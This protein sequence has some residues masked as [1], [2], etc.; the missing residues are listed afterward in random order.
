MNSTTNRPS[1]HKNPSNLHP[2]SKSNIG[3]A[4]S[5]SKLSLKKNPSIGKERTYFSLDAQK[6][7]RT[8]VAEQRRM[9]SVLDHSVSS[10]SSAE[11]LECAESFKDLIKNIKQRLIQIEHEFSLDNLFNCLRY[12]LNLNVYGSVT[13]QSLEKLARFKQT[14]VEMT[15]NTINPYLTIGIM[16]SLPKFFKLFNLLKSIF[17]IAQRDLLFNVL[18]KELDN[19]QKVYL[20]KLA[21]NNIKTSG[22]ESPALEL[23]SQTGEFTLKS[24]ITKT[25]IKILKK[26]FKCHQALYELNEKL[27]LLLNDHNTANVKLLSNE[28]KLS[29]KYEFFKSAEYILRLIPDILF[30][31]HLLLRLCQK[32]NELT[33]N[34]KEN[35]EILTKKA[36]SKQTKARLQINESQK[37]S[38]DVTIKEVDNSFISDEETYETVEKH[39]QFPSQHKVLPPIQKSKREFRD[40][41]D[42]FLQKRDEM[43]VCE[44]EM[45]EIREQLES[46]ISRTERCADLES[47]INSLN[48]LIA[49]TEKHL[50][51]TNDQQS[52]K[53][54]EQELNLMNYRLKLEKQDYEIEK[55]VQ[56]D[57]VE[58]INDA[59]M[60]LQDTR[61]KYEELNVQLNRLNN[62]MHILYKDLQH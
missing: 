1:I 51:E 8:K 62:E 46:L 4:K 41:Y 19:N 30:K 5:L 54:L 34:L 36:T 53:I 43:N 56:E 14:N 37:K 15:R 20:E 57:I 18:V 47:Q 40:I 27:A 23:Q 42:E 60:R 58:A 59:E 26:L 24:R 11:S 12:H 9:E 21:K 31:M 16:Q 55:S 32:C 39:Q 33:E 25:Q 44:S 61:F 22:F 6:N 29:Q 48:R 35:P 50:I 38:I 13:V 3:F 10:E 49:Q 45:D 17:K 2:I 28:S 52:R 7:K